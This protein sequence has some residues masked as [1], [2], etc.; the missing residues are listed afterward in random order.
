[1]QPDADQIDLGR[2]GTSMAGGSITNAY[3]VDPLKGLGGRR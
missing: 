2:T 1:M 3:T